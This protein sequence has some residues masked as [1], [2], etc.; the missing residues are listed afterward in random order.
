MRLRLLLTCLLLAPL[1]AR[2]QT[3]LDTAG[4]VGR[5]SSVA[6][7]TDG[8]PLI[9][10]RDETNGTVKVAHCDDAACSGATLST[11]DA[12]AYP[13]VAIGP[14][15]RGFIAYVSAN[16][17]KAAHCDDDACTTASIRVVDGPTVFGARVSVVTGGGSPFIVYMKRLDESD[18]ARVTTARCADAWCS[19]AT[20][21]VHDGTSSLG[22][23]DTA[24]AVGNDGVPLI[25]WVTYNGAA[26]IVRRCVDAACTALTPRTLETVP[27]E[28]APFTTFQAVEAPSLVIGADGRGLVAY[29][30]RNFLMSS[31]SYQVA[32]CADAAC[33]AFDD[34]LAMP[35]VPA[36]STNVALTTSPSGQ[37]WF[38]RNQSGR[39]RL[40]RCD[41]AACTS[42]TDTCALVGTTSV[43]LA[44]GA[45]GQPISTFQA[46]AGM[47]LGAAHDFAACPVPVASPADVVAQEHLFGGS[48]TV[49]VEVDVPAEAVATVDYATV[50]GTAVEGVDYA[51]TSGTLTFAGCCATSQPLAIPLLP[52]PTDEND[53]QFTVVFSNPQGLT[54]ADTQAVVTIMDD[55]APPSLAPAECAVL[56]GDAGTASC[57]FPVTL[58]PASGKTVQVAYFTVNGT[59]VAGSDYEA[60]SGILT[61]APG[62]A[63]RSVAVPVNGDTAVE[64]DELFSLVLSSPTNATVD[65]GNAQG[66]ILDDDGV[67]SNRGELGHGGGVTADLAAQPGPVADTDSYRLALPALS[68][69]QVVADA[70][71]GDLSPGLV[72]EHVG[73]DN[74]AV[75]GSGAPLGVGTAVGLSLQNRL[76]TAV[77]SHRVRVRSTACT[78]DCGADDVYRLRV[79]ETTAAV[80]RFNN[81]ATQATVLV[82]QNT[83]GLLLSGDADFWNAAGQRLATVPFAIPP[84]GTSVTSTG[85]VA[86][87]GGQSGSITLTHDGAYGALAGKAV[88]LEPDTGL[89]FDSPLSYKPR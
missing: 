19:A 8:R 78:T 20:V 31:A 23:K 33:T 89:S 14:D 53:E 28:R 17:L 26:P 41:D 9:A 70:V 29:V 71:S 46:S 49:S 50:G 56:E 7:G 68:S 39:L 64:P 32:H 3:L 42:R 67:S 51:P 87:L 13:S 55:D 62:V 44:W 63:S 58:T 37:P 12:G 35:S 15:G 36:T 45:D 88:A 47:D 24:A 16:A 73:A 2:A 80:P 25:A 4:D 86:G 11:I 60:T 77:V 79:Y 61:F 6:I 54:L 65:V 82:L 81:S 10:Y 18:G 84:H 57:A 85:S 38:V 5:T 69:W 75:L 83:T 72:L 27:A 48:A 43:A 34:V 1:P 52:D 66:V 22:L 59:A 40:S 74:T 76:T 21:S 30:F